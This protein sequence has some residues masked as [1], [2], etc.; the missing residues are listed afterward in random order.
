VTNRPNLHMYLNCSVSGKFCSIYIYIYFSIFKKGI[1][2]TVLGIKPACTV[3]T[4]GTFLIHFVLCA[5]L[6]FTASNL[7]I[8]VEC[9]ALII[10]VRQVWASQHVL[11]SSGRPSVFQDNILKWAMS[12]SSLYL[13]NPHF[14]NPLDITQIRQRIKCWQVGRYQFMAYVTAFFTQSLYPFSNFR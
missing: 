9:F 12:S 5:S 13:T 8:R 3:Y 10:F 1:D 11:V 7:T 6:K 4:K 14:T 2:K